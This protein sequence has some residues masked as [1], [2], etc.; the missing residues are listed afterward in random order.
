MSAGMPS[1]PGI[2]APAGIP[3]IAGIPIAIIMFMSSNIF[4]LF[5]AIFSWSNSDLN[6]S[7]L[8]A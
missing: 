2:P 3:G 8:L 4:L 6:D 7:C 5:C 1:A